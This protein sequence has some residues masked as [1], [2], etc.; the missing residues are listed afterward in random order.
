MSF[1]IT[2][3]ARP[4]GKVR[5]NLDDGKQASYF[6]MEPEFAR[7]FAQGIIALAQKVDD[8]LTTNPPHEQL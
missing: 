1:D 3:S 4:S 5:V 8:F 6:E 7:T 2:V